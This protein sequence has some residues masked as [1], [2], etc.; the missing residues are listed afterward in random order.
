MKPFPPAWK[1][2]PGHTAGSNS[3]SLGQPRIALKRQRKGEERWCG[4][5]FGSGGFFAYSAISLALVLPD[6]CGSLHLW[7]L[8]AVKVRHW[9]AGGY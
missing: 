3:A 9:G 5:G 8:L 4:C 1:Q 2:A 7:A 6:G